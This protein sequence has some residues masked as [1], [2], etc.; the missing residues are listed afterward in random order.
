MPYC[1]KCG[2]LNADDSKFCASCGRPTSTA[3]SSADQFGQRVSEGAQDFAKKM[4]QEAERVSE[5]VRRE[6]DSRF[7]RM[8][9]EVYQNEPLIGTISSGAVLVIIA[10][11]FLRYP[12]IF[13]VLGDYF[14]SMGELGAFIRPPRVILEATSFF[15]ASVGLWTFVMVVLRLLVQRSARRALNDVVGGLFSFYVAFVV[16]AY[17][18][19]R[20]GGVGA[21]ALVVV[22]L[23]AVVIVH[24][25]IAMVL[26]WSRQST[27]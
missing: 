21:L 23:G 22:G 15:F 4:Q 25:I 27:G 12:N 11:T 26:P 7:G 19:L 1:S 5:T 16:S 17:A 3:S 6:T 14:R 2:A 20:I 24:G 8:P 13:T 10:L 18:A 9:P